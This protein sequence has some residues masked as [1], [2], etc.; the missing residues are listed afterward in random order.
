MS[1]RK[2]IA[3]LGSTGSIGTQSLEVIRQQ[4]DF[5][6]V[7]VLSSFNNVALLIKQAEEFVPNA[8]VVG[9]VNKLDFVKEALKKLPVKVY[10]GVDA[11][12]E[13]VQMDTIDVVLTALVGY[14]GLKP[15]L[16]AIRAGKDIA[17]ANKETLVV[18]GKLV[19]ELAL[20]NNVNILPIDSEHSAIFQ[21]LVGESNNPIEKIGKSVV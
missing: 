19:T 10:G 4:K 14:A 18:A 7:E 11:L 20:K 12:S 21:C 8:V 1:D 2:K 13:I 17:L 3:I 16:N 6:E 15:T 9:D 5:F